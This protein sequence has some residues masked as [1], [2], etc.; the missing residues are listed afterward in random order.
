MVHALK[1]IHRMLIPTGCLI[2]IHP[3][4]EP[5][6]FEV[7]KEGKVLFAEA[8]PDFSPESYHDAD[9]AL[10]DAIQSHLFTLQQSGQFEY[11]V[12]AGSTAELSDYFE[13]QDAFAREPGDE[14]LTPGE[15][16]LFRRIDEMIDKHGSG[17]EVVTREKVHI[18]KLLPV[19]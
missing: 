8:D 11:L 2:D 9:K 10:K 13:I 6:L 16:E 5:Y 15:V 7:H 4:A 12:F 18:S 14:S 19:K 3:F 1:E 17:A